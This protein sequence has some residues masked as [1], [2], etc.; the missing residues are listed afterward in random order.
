MPHFDLTFSFGN[1]TTV[2]A[3]VGGIIRAEIWMHNLLRRLDLFSIEHEML[4]QDFCKRAGT[5]IGQLAT[6][7]KRI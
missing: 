3:I 1:V 2:I 4:L 5:T 6:R 7:G